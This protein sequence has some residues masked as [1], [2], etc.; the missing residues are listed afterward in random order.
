MTLRNSIPYY[1]AVV[2]LGVLAS[3]SSANK[4][5]VE[6]KIADADAQDIVIEMSENGYWYPLDTV[7]TDRNGNFSYSHEAIG[8]PDILRM[9][10]GDKTIY[11]PIDSVEKINV[12][13]SVANFDTDYSVSGTQSADMMMEVDRKIREVAAAKGSGT[14]LTDSIL[15][16][17]LGG[18]ILSDPS[19]IVAYY[20]INKNINGKPI[21]NPA[22]IRDVRIIGAV[23][24]AYNEFRPNDPRTKYLKTLFLAN[25]PQYKSN[26]LPTDT[27]QVNQLNFFE[28]DLSDNTGK[29]NKLSDIVA[30]N[31]VVVLNF[32][33]YTAQQ[34]PAF[35]IELAQMYEKYHNQG[36]EIF[37]VAIDPDEYQWKQTAKNLPWVT[38]YNPGT[39]GDVLRKYNVAGI[40]TTYILA[41]GELVKRVDDISKISS[42]VAKYL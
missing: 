19:G 29:Q 17:E 8:Y 24:N 42:E 38:V 6:G 5:K 13:S 37:Q 31:K 7:K 27:I 22:D 12:T 23:A 40:P 36:V 18:M 32:T 1:F 25:R 33:A 21:F 14:A 20:I 4:W 26:S 41:N 30:K 35:N 16:R 34:S 15:K 11:F 28:I 10:L 39:D 3:C 9:R 2:I